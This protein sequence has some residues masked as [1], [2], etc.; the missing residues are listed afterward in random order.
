MINN[1]YVFKSIAEALLSEYL[2]VYFV[3]A[4]TNE[5]IFY[6]GESWYRSLHTGNGG[7]D[8]YADVAKVTE[9]VIYDEDKHIFLDE[10]LKNVLLAQVK[11]N[12]VHLT[13]YRLVIDGRPVYHRTKL[14]RGTDKVDGCFIIGVQNVDKEARERLL[15]EKYEAERE[16]FNQ[17]AGILAEHY[18]TLYYV[19]IETNHYFEYS[20]TDAYK[21]LQIPKTGNDFFAESRKNME[22]YV[23]PEDQAEIIPKFEK[24]IILDNLSNARMCSAAYRLVVNGGIMHCRCSQMLA[25]D[26]KHIL[27]GIENI[28]DE[29]KAREAY[30]ET[31]RQNRKFSQMTNS[32]VS[33]YDIVFYVNSKTGRYSK[34][35]T[36]DNS[37]EPS[38]SLK[39]ENFFADFV[40]LA[41]SDVHPEDKDRI[42]AVVDRD[43]MISTLENARQYAEDHRRIIDGKT[44]YTRLKVMRS[45]DNIHFIVGLENIND[46]VKKEQEQIK[47]LDR[48]N[49]LAR[50]DGLT[51]AKNMTAYREFEDSIQES[52]DS[53]LGHS[54]FA[55]AVCDINDLKSIND[56]KGHKAGDEYIRS[57][58][59]M[60]CGIFAHSPVFRI[61]GD[62]F[63]VVLAGGDYDRR[64]RLEDILKKRS[65]EN[66][67]SGEG[68]AVAVGIAVYDA[69]ND[70]SVSDV[71]RRADENM[72]ADKAVLKAGRRSAGNKN[73]KEKGILIPAERKRL[74]DGL[75]ETLSVVNNQDY[76]Y[77]CDMVYDYSR[78]SKAA[79]DSY[80]LPSEYMYGAGAIW[81]EHIHTEDRDTFH[82]AIRQIF[83]G[84]AVGHDMQ[85]RAKRIN[86]EYNVCT[87]RGVVLKNENGEPEYFSGTIKDHGIQSNL[88]SLTGLRNQYGF[89]ED[90]QANIIQNKKMILAFVGISKFTEINEI[91]GY[92]F[93]NLAIQK[94]GRFLFEHVGNYGNVYRLDG[95]KFAILGTNIPLK[96]TYRRYEDLRTCFREGM[97]IDNKHIYLELNASIIDVDNFNIDPQTIMTCLTFAY[98]ESKT[99]RH[100]DM[101]EFNNDLG[102]GSRQ[103]M[104]RFHAIRASITKGY[105]G[106]YLL[107]QPVVDAQTEKLTG[108]EALLRWKNDEYGVVPPDEFI[109]LLEKDPLFPDLGKWILT[110]AV[111]DAKKVLE[112][113]PDFVINVN[114]SYTQL[115][116]AGFVDMVM[117]ILDKEGYPPEHLCLEITERCRLLDIDLLRNIVVSLRGKGVQI[118]LDD[119]GTGFSSIGIVKDLPFNTIKIDR[120]FVLEIEKDNIERELI[121]S[122]VHVATTC[123][124]VVCI[125][126]IETSGMGE[127]LRQYDVHS[128]QGYYYSKPLEYEDF[129]KWGKATGKLL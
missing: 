6:S 95:T 104:E 62:E 58:F 123:G 103:R 28:N 122:F 114:L 60:I 107:Y 32:L 17:I 77:I 30:E 56:I 84:D 120:S 16:I 18:D 121:K 44:V 59:R 98:N 67:E 49:A 43:Y 66:L 7:K 46:E 41:D 54:P 69:L 35:S 45:E 38:V 109:P 80:G 126:G 127:I 68:P 21:D 26:K 50:C 72:Y 64:E 12:A 37:A 23:H 71:F 10:N 8:F 51:G 13:D 22:K 70:R 118:A 97:D 101:V 73:G 105:K 99:R 74:L 75:F 20:S 27:V 81:E 93:G 124:A 87:C 48:A 39:G 9:K 52:I 128:F 115:E 100:G 36:G 76:V 91:Y 25:S 88:D 79:V 111:K 57:A 112:K 65:A 1:E 102:N 116:K 108:A 47:A 85:Y 33:R 94:F 3:N 83:D 125:E 117:D 19:D 119:F 42:L 86:G 14:I 40:E 53:G 63:A 89:F 55:I 11:D 15:S 106:F 129:I 92:N 24:Q 96:E 61:G 90:I 78:W 4:K 31:K 2:C 113:D 29:V 5:Y 34:Y 82:E 110:T